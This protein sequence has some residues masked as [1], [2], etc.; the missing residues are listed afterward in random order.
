MEHTILYMTMLENW[1][2]ALDEGENICVYFRI[3]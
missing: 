3:S 2:S 1:K